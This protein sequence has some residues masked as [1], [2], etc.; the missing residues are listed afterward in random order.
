MKKVKVPRFATEAAEAKWWD[1]HMDV[2]EANLVE[3]IKTGAAQRGGPRRVIQERRAS[4]NITIR[5]ATA[6]IERA[7]ALAA[8][9]GIGYQTFIKMLLKEALD[10]ESRSRLVH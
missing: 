1:D 2:V 4:K 5:V 10:R 9:K 6:D 7:R 3:G 8:K